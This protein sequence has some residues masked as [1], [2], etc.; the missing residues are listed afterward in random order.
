MA[1]LFFWFDLGVEADIQFLSPP[2]REGQ[3]RAA[4]IEKFLIRQGIS[5][6]INTPPLPLP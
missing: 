6:C 1:P 2:F 4:C 3:G 5:V